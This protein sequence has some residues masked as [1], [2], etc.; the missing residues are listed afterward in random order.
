MFKYHHGILPPV[1]KDLFLSN[2]NVHSHFT[3]QHR[4]LHVPLSGK[5]IL[6]KTVRVTGVTLYNHFNRH[7]S[8]GMTYDSYKYNLRKFIR[9]HDI[10]NVLQCD[11]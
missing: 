10:S 5:T 7:L 8:M 3:R 9:D 4:N 6:S 11:V 2:M 1:F